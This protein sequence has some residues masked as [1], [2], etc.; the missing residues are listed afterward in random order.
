M[1]QD[2]EPTTAQGPAKTRTVWSIIACLFFFPTGAAALFQSGKVH[3]AN[4]AGRYDLSAEAN[5]QVKTWQNVTGLII[6]GYVVLSIVF[7]VIQSSN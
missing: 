6:I 3:A 5:K 1:S 2:P 7:A 4:Q